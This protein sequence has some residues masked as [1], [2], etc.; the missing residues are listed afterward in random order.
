MEL[1]SKP[2]FIENHC[3]KIFIFLKEIFFADQKVTIRRDF[4]NA[5]D[6]RK[7]PPRSPGQGQGD[8]G[9]LKF[10]GQGKNE[11]LSTQFRGEVIQGRGQIQFEAGEELH[12]HTGA[13]QG[14]LEHVAAVAAVYNDILAV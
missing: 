9:V 13:P 11:N 14:A 8:R 6:R 7:E 12:A 4:R 3:R 5:G 2:L 10:N 1:Y